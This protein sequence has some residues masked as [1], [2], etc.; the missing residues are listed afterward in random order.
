MKETLNFFK[1]LYDKI[2]FDGPSLNSITCC[3]LYLVRH[4]FLDVFAMQ[5]TLRRSFRA[6]GKVVRSAGKIKE[7]TDVSKR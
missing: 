7:E 3:S 1:L 6:V 2:P 5:E 4:S